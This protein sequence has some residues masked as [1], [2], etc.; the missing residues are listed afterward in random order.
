MELLRRLHPLELL[1]FAVSAITGMAFGP[2][3]WVTGHV[4]RSFLYLDLFRMAGTA[5]VMIWGFLMCLAILVG[6]IGL[7]RNNSIMARVACVVGLVLSTVAAGANVTAGTL[8][9]AMTVSIPMMIFWG[10]EY[11]HAGRDAVD[12]EE[13]S[14][15]Q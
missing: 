4:G 1:F 10:Y 9:T 2:F 5:L 7:L 3:L 8:L 6:L 15:L 11:W 14:V 13:Q 12:G